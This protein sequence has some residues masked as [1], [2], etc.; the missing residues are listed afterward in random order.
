MTESA[1]ARSLVMGG[2]LSVAVVSLYLLS[3]CTRVRFQ[4]YSAC[5]YVVIALSVA[6]VLL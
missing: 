4:S 3:C 1:L 6:V 2:A 5:V